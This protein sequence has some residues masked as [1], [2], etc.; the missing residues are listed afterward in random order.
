MI[1]YRTVLITISYL[2]ICESGISEITGGLGHGIVNLFDVHTVGMTGVWWKDWRTLIFV[3][4]Y[5]LY[6]L[7]VRIGVNRM[8]SLYLFL[9]IPLG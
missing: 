4:I 5:L 3:E 2:K 7:L 8:I 9:S 6:F 1:L